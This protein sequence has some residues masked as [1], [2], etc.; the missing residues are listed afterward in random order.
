MV[1]G[2]L[3]TVE[4]PTIGASMVTGVHAQV[5]VY[6]KESRAAD[7]SQSMAKC[8][9]WLPFTAVAMPA[10][11]IHVGLVEY[12]KGSGKAGLVW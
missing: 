1:S 4:E 8:C 3:L 6:V 10:S 9:L 2:N 12:G 11:R 7:H 5:T